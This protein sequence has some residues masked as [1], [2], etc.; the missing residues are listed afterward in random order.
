MAIF[1]EH[2]DMY[3]NEKILLECFESELYDVLA[4]I[5]SS[6]IFDD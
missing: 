2:D 1:F 5:I 6:G 4:Q 3:L